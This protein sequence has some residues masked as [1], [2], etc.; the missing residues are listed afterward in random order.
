MTEEKNKEDQI[1]KI[2]SKE[3]IKWLITSFVIIA[4]FFLIFA[5]GVQIGDRKARFSCDW[6]NNYQNN[7]AGPR[8]GFGQPWQN[9]PG[10]DFINANGVF[11]EII[12]INENDFIIKGKGGI[13]NIIIINQ[14]TTIQRFRDN[15]GLKDLKIGEFVVVIGSPNKSGQIEAKL[16]RVLPPGPTTMQLPRNFN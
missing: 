8:D 12:K 11:G 14:D 1:N 10:G 3:N 13:E 6:A 2:F 7:F 5:F 16:I 9:L 15:I 4:L